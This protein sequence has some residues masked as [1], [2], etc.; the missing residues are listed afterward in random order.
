M[1]IAIVYHSLSGNTRRIAELLAGRLG[2]LV[3]AADLFEVHDLHQY[4]TLTA[5]MVGAPRAMRGESAAI[6]PAEIDV[7]AYDL[8][9][10]GTPVWAF[11]PTPAANGAVGAL[12]G[13]D[14][15]EAVVFVTSG[16]APGDA[17]GR[18]ST[19]LEQRGIRVRGTVLFD[20]RD[21]ENEERL[22]EL[23]AIVTRPPSGG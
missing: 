22:A 1:R 23:V 15:K 3:E 7:A 11:A 6:D 21:L 5:Y 17:A 4:S 20:R 16:G 10:V 8:I 19:A 12:R 13:A 18:L 14:G 9:V 2:P